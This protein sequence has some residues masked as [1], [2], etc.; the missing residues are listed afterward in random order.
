M[1]IEDNRHTYSASSLHPRSTCRWFIFILLLALGIGT[2]ACTELSTRSAPIRPTRISSNAVL[3][4]IETYP[5]SGYA[6]VAVQVKGRNWPSNSLVLLAL[7][8]TLGRSD[9]LAATNATADGSIETEFRYPTSQRWLAPGEYTILAYTGNGTLQAIVPFNV[10]TAS[11]ATPTSP[12]TETPTALLTSTA[13]IPSPEEM[14]T[15]TITTPTPIPPAVVEFQD[16]R[17]EYWDNPYLEGPPALIRDDPA[18]VF[19]WGLG[20]P[21]GSMPVD[22][23]SA[24][25]SRP[26]Y[27]TEG[28]YRFFLEVDDGARLYIDNVPVLD[29]WREGSPRTVFVDFALSDG[30]HLLQVD[31]F[32]SAQRALIR[33][34][35]ERW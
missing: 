5:N 32:E 33:F 17:G 1:S 19:D 3:P 34:W 31:Y 20:S 7:E 23:F 11:A 22:Y 13:T 21:A 27:F 4:V 18:I 9:I 35:W 2:A 10:T 6:G 14:I 24:R 28:V 12:P 29:E 26:L 15:P 25:W 30:V 8:D 16:W